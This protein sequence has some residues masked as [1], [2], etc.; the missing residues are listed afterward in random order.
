[1]HRTTS[2]AAIIA[3]FRTTP[4]LTLSPGQG[5]LFNRLAPYLEAIWDAARQDDWP[6]FVEAVRE[7]YLAGLLDGPLP[8]SVLLASALEED[9]DD[10]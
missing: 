10:A 9:D 2:F 1:M 6:A 4:G 7:V 8:L 5:I 3:A